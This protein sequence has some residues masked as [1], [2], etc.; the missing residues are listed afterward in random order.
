MDRDRCA[1]ISR[2][3]KTSAIW[4]PIKTKKEGKKKRGKERKKEK[5]KN[6]KKTL[7]GPAIPKGDH[8]KLNISSEKISPHKLLSIQSRIP[9]KWT[10]I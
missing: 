6:K 1:K 2:Y 5:E 7:Y 8:Q 3:L 10:A 9:V 4:D